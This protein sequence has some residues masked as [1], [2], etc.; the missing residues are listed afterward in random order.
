MEDVEVDGGADV[1]HVGDEAELLGLGQEPVQQPAVGEG[2]VE[3]A[4]AG[5]IPVLLGGLGNYTPP[6][7]DVLP[8]HS[9][10]ESR[11]V[12]EPLR[13]FTVQRRLHTLPLKNE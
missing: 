12:N 1:V 8:A 2:C 10:H 9:G 3:V 7:Q 6:E 11:A 4:V 13:R 5:R